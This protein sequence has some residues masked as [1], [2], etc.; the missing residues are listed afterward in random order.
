MHEVLFY[1]FAALTLVP[2]ILMVTSRN[3]VNGAML[4]IASFVGTATLFAMLSAFLLAVLQ[5]LVY[6]GAVVVLF[7]FIIMMMGV[8]K[9]ARLTVADMRKFLIG[10]SFFVLLAACP[11]LALMS[12]RG[13][14]E[15][16]AELPAP[17][18]SASNFGLMLFTKYQLPFEITG[19]LLLAA[20]VGVIYVSQRTPD[21]EKPSTE[22]DVAK[23]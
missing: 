13:G 20:M 12:G 14:A 5:I 2:A 4:M 8:A 9:P 3:T 10:L 15:P 22:A 7:L 21:A 17:A 6:V 16:A 19:F 1:L 23:E 18:A 11:L